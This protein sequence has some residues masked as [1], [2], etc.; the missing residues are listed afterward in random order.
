[1]VATKSVS[2]QRGKTL[3]QI[4][5][6]RLLIQSQEDLAK[7]LGVSQNWVSNHARKNNRF[8][9]QVGLRTRLANALGID[10]REF[11]L[12][13]KRSATERTK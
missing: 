6:E 11:A 8:T 13:C 7:E 3:D 4:L 2:N 9:V 5:N 12:I 10:P 1:M